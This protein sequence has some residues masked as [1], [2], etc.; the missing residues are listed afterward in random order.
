MATTGFNTFFTDGEEEVTLIQDRCAAMGVR[1]I[2]SNGFAEGGNGMTELAKVVVDEIDAGNN[3]FHPL[4][5]WNDPV[6]EKIETIAKE[7][8]GAKTVEYSK[9]AQKNLRSIETLGL[10]ALPVCMAKTQKS[11]S[12][13]ASLLARPEGF[14]VTVRE[15]EFARGAGFIIPILGNMMRM[16]GLPAVPASEG[17]TIDNNGKISGL[18]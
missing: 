17:M 10:G 8:Y 6:K 3:D 2:V 18:S 1:A 11:F 14:I 13:N 12:D 15:F 7:I 16:P 4:Y 5:D 9:K